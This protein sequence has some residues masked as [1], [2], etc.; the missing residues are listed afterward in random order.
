MLSFGAI[1]IA[2]YAGWTNNW[3]NNWDEQLEQLGTATVLMAHAD[4]VVQ[5]DS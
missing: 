1:T 3:T 5:T 4:Q 2:P